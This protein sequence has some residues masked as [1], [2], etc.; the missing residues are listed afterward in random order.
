MLINSLLMHNM[1]N[2]YSTVY[3]MLSYKDKH[4]TVGRINCSLFQF[5]ILYK[6]LSA[7]THNDYIYASYL[8]GIL[9]LYDTIHY[10]FY[11]TRI[12]DYLHHIITI[13]MIFFVNSEYGSLDILF[14]FN[15][16]VLLFESTNPPMSISWI[17]NK[18]GY[19]DYIAFKIFSTFTFLYW[20]GIRIVYL[21][22]YIYSI[23]D[24]K[25]QLLIL[26]FFGLNLFWFKALINV[27]L[28]VIFKDTT[29][30]IV[31]IK[32]TE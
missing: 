25:Y 12:T 9:I 19:K 28:K 8:F 11:T 6:Y 18:F 22:Y 14:I 16:L 1:L 10:L 21:S 30:K 4:E 26:P 29:Q 17:A 2:T 31:Q 23:G 20:T 5:F 24:F 13:S 32:N 3:P 15:Y 27:Y 7:T